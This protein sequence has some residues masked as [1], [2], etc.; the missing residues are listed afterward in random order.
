MGMDA[1][2]VLTD[3]E[4]LEMECLA[5]YAQTKHGGRFMNVTVF[6]DGFAD[7]SVE[8]GGE[9]SGIRFAHV[10]IRKDGAAEAFAC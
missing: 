7:V 10:A 5:R 4:I 2:E 6:P 1:R 9:G 8:V 3:H